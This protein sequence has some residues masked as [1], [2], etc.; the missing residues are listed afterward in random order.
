MMMQDIAMHILDIGM[1]S[2][3]A[4][5]DTVIITIQNNVDASRRIITFEDNGCGMSEEDVIQAQNP[6]YTSRS[7]RKVGLGIPFIKAAAEM[8]GGCFSLN[9][10]LNE[11]TVL[12]VEFD[13]SN[14][15][16]PPLGNVAD[17]IVSLM[18]FDESINLIFKYYWNNSLFE[19]STS[20]IKM[21]LEDVSMSEPAIQIWLTEYIG[22][23][24]ERLKKE[25]QS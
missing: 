14:I 23:N 9:S 19:V 1:N 3:K 17:S 24:I 8:S 18:V 16:C 13:T 2:I 6:F 20:Q 11:G 5:A 15:D 10:K 4:K 22:E 21:E 12:K 7:T 25:E